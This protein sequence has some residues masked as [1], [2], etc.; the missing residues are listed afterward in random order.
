MTMPTPVAQMTDDEKKATVKE[1]T[2]L[3]KADGGWNLATL[4][5]WERANRSAQDTESSDGYAT[6]FVVYVLRRAGVPANDPRVQKGVAWLKANQRESGRWFSR[7]LNNDNKHY[8]THVGT[9]FAVMA[10]SECG[11][12]KRN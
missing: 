9:A 12:I 2:G 6:G 1:L 8:I 4:G 11:E 10:L 5:K 7:S 3:Q